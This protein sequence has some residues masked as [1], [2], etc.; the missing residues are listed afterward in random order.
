MLIQDY[1]GDMLIFIVVGLHQITAITDPFYLHFS[2]NDLLW[3]VLDDELLPIL[4]GKGVELIVGV[5]HLN[6]LHNP[7]LK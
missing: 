1:H 5:I 6:W 2:P 3:F 7:F 4:N